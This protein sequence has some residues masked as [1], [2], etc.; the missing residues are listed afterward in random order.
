VVLLFTLVVAS[1][2]VN[3]LLCMLGLADAHSLTER[4]GA[5]LYTGCG[6]LIKAALDEHRVYKNP[7]KAAKQK[8]G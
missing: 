3:C 7:H 6:A 1:L 4:L 8:H 2:L 5:I